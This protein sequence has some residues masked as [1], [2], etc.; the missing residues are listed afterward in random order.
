MNFK[1]RPYKDIH[2]SRCRQIYNVICSYSIN[3]MYGYINTAQI[4]YQKLCF[5]KYKKIILYLLL[6]NPKL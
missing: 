1:I 5:M 3:K 2:F 6:I 4:L